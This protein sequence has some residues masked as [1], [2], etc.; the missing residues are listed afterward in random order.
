[1][2]FLTPELD[3]FCRPSIIGEGEDQ[4]LNASYLEWKSML[5]PLMNAIN[6]KVLNAYFRNVAKDNF[7][8]IHLYTGEPERSASQVSYHNL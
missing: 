5:D 7:S 4:M 3:Y 2:S 1:M 6:E 8:L